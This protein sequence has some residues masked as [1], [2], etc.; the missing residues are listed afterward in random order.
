MTEF[1]VKVTVDDVVRRIAR[2]ERDALAEFLMT[3]GRALL[4]EDTDG[5][6]PV[7]IDYITGAASHI[8]EASEELSRAANHGKA[9]REPDRAC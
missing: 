7:I 4:E 9:E 3:L 5:V 8:I 2:M 6:D 1:E